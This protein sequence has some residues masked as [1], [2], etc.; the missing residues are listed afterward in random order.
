MGPKV[1]AACHR[2]CQ[3]LERGARG[4]SRTACDILDAQPSDELELNRVLPKLQQ[5]AGNT[6]VYFVER[7]GKWPGQA[8]RPSRSGSTHNLLDPVGRRLLAKSGG[9]GQN[10]Q[11]ESNTNDSLDSPKVGDN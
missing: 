5:L 4:C 7:H 9:G 10:L 1:G 2:S 6:A 3:K 8:R 11:D